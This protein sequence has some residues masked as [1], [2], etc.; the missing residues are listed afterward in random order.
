MD[1]VPM[2]AAEAV[3]FA[4]ISSQTLAIMLAAEMTLIFGY[5]AGLHFFLRRARM[6]L[7]IF[8]HGLLLLALVYF[9]LAF[10]FNFGLNEYVGSHVALSIEHG[11]LNEADRAFMESADAF[12]RVFA[13]VMNV[14][15]FLVMVG[16]TYLAFFFDLSK[17]EDAK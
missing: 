13:W 10:V 12:G 14:V 2:T 5:L 9:W 3:T 4:S 17:P 8:S 16:L 11:V 6:P 15:Q 7:R 1:Y